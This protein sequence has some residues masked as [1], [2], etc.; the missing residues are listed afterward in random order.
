M[1]DIIVIGFIN[2]AVSSSHRHQ[3]QLSSSS[4][5]QSAPDCGTSQPPTYTTMS[6]RH[7]IPFCVL[8][9]MTKNIR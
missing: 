2:W 7:R 8:F 3:C 4:D 1:M 6:Q 9:F 5:W